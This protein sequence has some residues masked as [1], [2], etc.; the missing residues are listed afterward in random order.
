LLAVILVAGLFYYGR[1]GRE[2]PRVLL[3]PAA[4]L[5]LLSLLITWGNVRYF[6]NRIARLTDMTR[7][8]GARRRRADEFDEIEAAVGSLGAALDSAAAERVQ[9]EAHAAARLR[10][11]A[12]MLAAAVGDALAQLDG[13]RLPLQILL[14]APFG[15]LNEN[16]EE[17]LRDARAAADAIDGALRRLGEV[18]DA[19]RGA[20]A[21]QLDPVQVN[22]VVRSVLPIARAAAERRGARVQA[23]LEP[24]LPRVSADRTRLAEALALLSGDA[25]EAS[26][27]EHPLQLSTARVAGGVVVRLAPAGRRG[28]PPTGAWILANRL[29]AAQGATL[30][31][32]DDAWEIRFAG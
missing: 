27:A 3:L 20:L 23:E 16:Q 19:D 14:E 8:A 4:L 30:S 31:K 6:V 9:A 5:T 18:A 22:D 13:M 15:D 17:L 25:A 29:A 26:D 24:A 12:T 1:V 21:A 11:E 32:H 2:A 7:G 10:D 28:H